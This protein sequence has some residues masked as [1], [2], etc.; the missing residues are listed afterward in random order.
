MYLSS[1]LFETCINLNSCVK[2][3][4]IKFKLNF[5]TNHLNKYRLKNFATNNFNTYKL[6]W[7]HKHP[8]QG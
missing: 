7:I 3:V 1:L 4:Y 8:N 5:T 6:K 2:T